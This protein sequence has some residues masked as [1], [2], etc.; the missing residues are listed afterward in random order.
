MRICSTVRVNNS[1]FGKFLIPD[2]SDG[3]PKKRSLDGGGWVGGV[4][5]IQVFWGFLEL[6]ESQ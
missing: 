3:F 2:V 5:S 1:Y 4:S 6:I